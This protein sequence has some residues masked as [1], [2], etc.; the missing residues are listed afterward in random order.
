MIDETNWWKEVDFHPKKDDAPVLRQGDSD[1]ATESVIYNLQVAL[2]EA[3]E[4][5]GA[6]GMYGPGTER[7]VRSFQRRVGL[8]ADGTYGPKTAE[9]LAG[10]ENPRTLKQADLEWAA[11]TLGWDVAVVMAV[12]EVESRGQGFFSNDRP[13]I[14]FERHWMRRRLKTHGLKWR[15]WA[16]KYP[17]IVSSSTGGYKGGTAE[18]GRLALAQSIHDTSA[19]ESASWG[20]YQI[21]GFHW[22]TLGYDSVQHYVEEMHKGERQHLEAF[23]AFNQANP[24]LLKAG[25]EKDFLTYARGYNGRG[26]KGYDHRM[27]TAYRKHETHLNA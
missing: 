18:Y 9:A 11:E 8:V 7:A 1:S 21:M 4:S 27:A 14:L 5:L 2:R 6:D 25:R 24:T 15:P 19:L 13:A 3:G 22:Q 26:Q 16:S 17:N 10:Y 23:V 12:S 20:A